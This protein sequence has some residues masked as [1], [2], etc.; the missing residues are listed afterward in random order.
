MLKNKSIICIALPTWEGSY[1]KSTVQLMT[2]LAKDNKVLYVEYA[3]TY[4]DVLKGILG[5]DIPYRRIL[6]IE[7]RIRQIPIAEG[8][9]IYVLNLPPVLPVNWIKNPDTYHRV[10]EWSMPKV[11]KAIRKAMSKLDMENPIII[12]AFNP[13]LGN[14]L[15]GHLNEELQLYYCYDGCCYCGC[16]AAVADDY[17]GAGG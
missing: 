1:L 16:R 13:F 8:K 3:F 17:V 9:F 4:K 7:S 2:E 11:R 14:H 6:G 12:N 15:I 10:S 5:K